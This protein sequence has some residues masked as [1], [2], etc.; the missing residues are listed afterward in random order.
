MRLR[1]KPVEFDF[2]VK[3]EKSRKNQQIDERSRPLTNSEPIQED[4]D[5]E[6][7]TLDAIDLRHQPK[8]VEDSEH[9]EEL[10]LFDVQ[11]YKVNHDIA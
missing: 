9:R 4:D 1:L 11:Y 5:D 10:D 8:S 6:V 7:L 3:Y 2:D